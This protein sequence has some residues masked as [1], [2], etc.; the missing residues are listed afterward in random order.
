M[1]VEESN[2]AHDFLPARARRNVERAF[3]RSRFNTAMAHFINVCYKLCTR[4]A[5]FKLL[6]YFGLDQA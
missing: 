4:L 3:D 6:G 1:K 2:H 5:Y